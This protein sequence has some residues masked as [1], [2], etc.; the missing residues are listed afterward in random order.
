MAV[1]VVALAVWAVSETQRSTAERV[2]DESRA[3]A[4]MQIAMLDQETGVRGFALTRQRPYLQPFIDGVREFNDASVDAREL[5]TDDEQRRSIAKVTRTANRWRAL[6]E[7]DIGFVGLQPSK[8]A[9]RPPKISER[10]ALFDE[11]RREGDILQRQLEDER[12]E[13]LARAGLMSVVVILLLAIVFFAVGLYLIERE[14]RR[15]RARRDRDRRYRETQG[16][17]A[18]AMQIMRDESE[19]HQLVKA[20][21]ERTI[22]GADVAI[23]NRNNSD[24][25]LYAATTIDGAPE[26]AAKLVDAEPESCL[27][28]RLGHAH[29]QGAG[30]DPLLSCELCG[31]S[32]TEVLCTPSLVGG[33][34]IGSVLVRNDRELHGEERRRVADSVSQASPVLANLRNLAIAE[35]RAATDAL[36]GLPNSRSCRDNLKRMVAHAGRT[37][38]PLSAVMLDLDHFKQINDR[39]GHGAGD[40]VLAGVGEVLNATLRGSDFGGRYGGEEF[41]LLLPGTDHEGALEVSEKLRIAVEA[42]EFQQIDLKVTASFGIASYPLD[43]LDADALVRMSDRALYAAKAKGRNRVELIDAPSREPT[44]DQP[45]L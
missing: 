30:I 24:N 42:L 1:G 14:I 32:A 37:V 13:K 38:T 41:L 16:E 45:S 43:A 29:E 15:V 40:D 4:R 39:F 34:V 5:A 23:L 25:R 11:F 9:L 3:A 36:T 18:D 6:A 12:N 10:K 21:L 7:Q 17:F 2:F 27:A 20:H 35:N 8:G 44:A 22:E 31:K 33:E 19:A 26:L 28:V